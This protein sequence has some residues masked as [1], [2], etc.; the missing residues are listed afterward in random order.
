MNVQKT[1]L[2]YLAENAVASLS[3]TNAKLLA[4]HY[5]DEGI[6]DS[7][8][9]INL[10]TEFEEVFGITFSAEDMQS[11]EFQTVA[12]LIGIIERKFAETS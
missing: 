5:L 7:L 4:C 3:E 8:G 9:I 1:V 10:V 6:I 12:G 2:T 11:Y